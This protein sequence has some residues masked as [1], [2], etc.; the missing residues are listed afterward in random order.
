MA[1]AFLSSNNPIHTKRALLIG[2]NK[3]KKN[4][5][6]RYCINDAEDL[7]NKLDRIDFEI[8]VG[9]DLTYEQMVRMIETFNDKINP[10]DLILFFFAGHGCQWSHLNFLMPI[11]DNQ[12]KTNTDLE[13][14][15]INAQ[16]A[17]E[18]IMSLCPSAAIF[19]LDCCQNS[20]VCESSNS[21]GLTSMRAVAGSFIGFACDANKIALSE[22]S[23]GRNSLFIYHLLQHID[24]PNLTIDDIMYNVCDG[25]M[26]ETNDDQCPFPISSLRRKVYLNQQFTAA[27]SKDTVCAPLDPLHAVRAHLERIDAKT[28]RIN[29]KTDRI[30]VKTDRID[31][32]TDRTDTKTDLILANTQTIINQIKEVMV[33]MYELHEFTTPRYFFILPAKH[34]DWTV[35]NTMQEWYHLHY[36]LYFLC[37]CSAEPDNMHVAPH[38]GYSIKKTREFIVKY[39]PYL[40]T[41]LQVAQILC[42]AGS[43]VIPQ[44]DGVSKAV[45]TGV[46]TILPTPD[47]QKEMEQQL[48]LVEKSLDRV[49]HKWTQSDSIMLGQHKSRGVPLQGPDLREVERYL[50]VADNKHSLGNLYRTVTVDGHVRWVCLKHY[51]D[52][53]FNNAM[54]KYIDQLEAMGGQS[55]LF[56]H[57]NINT[58]W[59]QYGITIAGG[60]GHGNQLNQ[61]SHPEGIYVDDDHRTIYSADC[62]NSRIVEWKYGAENSQVVAGGN[63]NGNGNL[64]DQLNYPTDVIVDKKNDSVI[65]CDRWNR[66]VVRWSPQNGTNEETIIFDIDCYGL[67]M[68]NNGDLYVS[69]WKKNEVRRWKQGEK[70]GTIV[71]G[72]NGQGDH[73]NQL[74]CPTY[75][76]VDEDHSIYVSDSDNHR[77]MKWMKGAKEGI[78]V[79]GGKGKGNSL[80][81]LSD[82]HGVV[83]DH[84][85]NVYVADCGNHR[86]MRWCEGSYEGSIAVGVNGKGEQANQLNCPTGLSFDVR[87]NLYVADCWNHRIQKFDIDSK[88]NLY[89]DFGKLASNMSDYDISDCDTGIQYRQE[90]LVFNEQNQLTTNSNIDEAKNSI[91]KFIET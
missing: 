44:L 84:L 29:A 66:R 70:E 63:G 10:G 6:L 72:G 36:K 35:L 50:D 47:K 27:Q 58:K 52:I 23:N 42:R 90:S 15:A 78:V 11:D 74:H 83:V 41:T 62:W 64:S 48:D 46:V 55:I 33:Q 13:Y 68:D 51:D 59:K 12:I 9:I 18:N 25:V 85:G 8:T 14:R 2:N 49:D 3:Y 17:L 20:F 87:G 57:I 71:A 82:P 67:T 21:N 32:K 69:D 56:N 40:R 38:N 73:L 4:S 80:T 75:I 24:Q 61:L 34:S 60:N 86:I 89:E 16:S 88:F 43:L 91:G 39:A 53:S 45:G 1:A 65:I 54:L 79:A 7:A 19:L 22:S 5:Q 77:V 81:Q 30:D 31:V 76:F 37:E 28:D 26:K